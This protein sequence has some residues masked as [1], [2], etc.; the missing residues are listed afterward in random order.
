MVSGGFAFC[1]IK[2]MAG[3]CWPRGG[4]GEIQKA[5]NQMGK[6]FTDCYKSKILQ[7]NF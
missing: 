1:R 7:K 3:D 2:K 6:V 4:G 5:S